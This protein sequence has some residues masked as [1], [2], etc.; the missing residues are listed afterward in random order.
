VRMF[1]KRTTG[2]FPTGFLANG[3]WAFNVQHESP[4]DA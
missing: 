2:S 4:L 3:S 1:I